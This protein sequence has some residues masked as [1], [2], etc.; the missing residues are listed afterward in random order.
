[1]TVEVTVIG[2][3]LAGC[4]AASVLSAAGLPVRL[5]EM[6]PL[7]TT[8]AHTSGELAEIVCS[9]SLG[10]TAPATSKRV[11][12]DELRRLGSLVLA[13]AEAHAVPAGASLAVDRQ[14]FSAAMTRAVAALPGVTLVR[15]EV[16][17]LPADGPVLVA[18]GPL[19]SDA[20]AS[21]LAEVTGGRHLAF[22]DA[23]API[24]TAESLDHGVL[25][26]A[27]R[28]GRGS[29]DFLNLPLDRSQYDAF[30]AGLLA[31]D[32]VADKPFEPLSVFEGCMPIEVMAARGPRTLAFGPMR[33]VGLP[34]PRTGRLPHAVVQLRRED[35]HGQLYNL[36][37]FQTRL[38]HGEQKAL[39]RTL[40]GMGRA[41][42]VRLG[43]MHRNT[44][45]NTPALLSDDL[46][47]RTRPSLWFGGLLIGVE[48]Y[49]ECA[50][51][52]LVAALAIVA[53]MRGLDW[54]P[55]PRTSLLGG[56]LAHLREADPA[57]FQPM[58]VNFGLLPPAGAGR[59]GKP[60]RRQAA[61]ERALADLDAWIARQRGR[62]LLPE[63]VQRAA[64]GG[65]GA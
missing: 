26:P 5:H 28:Y 30:V 62:E 64:I 43:S 41:E 12:L 27:S 50:A 42:F 35:R 53:R 6:R 18:T 29:P 36:V 23:I 19:T 56:L 24:V 58:N 44:F 9:N 52:G 39:L 10:S 16:E 33:P 40:P 8:P 2:G 22:H 48:G 7:R 32:T 63:P 1:M 57:H 31:A 46:S 60:A 37:G 4:E 65:V 25:Y 13:T 55:L 17:R 14:A 59:A 20:L 34:D 45:L 47:L 3:G 61:A 51:S 38:R 21:S 54:E 49:A 15:G 11:L